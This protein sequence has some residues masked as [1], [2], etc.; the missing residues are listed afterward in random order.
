MAVTDRKYPIDKTKHIGLEVEFLSTYDREQL[1]AIL[2]KSKNASLYHLHG[3]SSV[4]DGSRRG[5]ELSVVFKQTALL[6]TLKILNADLMLIRATVNSTCGLHVHLDMRSRDRVACFVKLAK[7]QNMLF[8]MVAKSRNN[9]A[10]CEKV[11]A[12]INDTPEDVLYII[13][14]S[15]HH[16]CAID[17]NVAYDEHETIEVR[18]HH[19][20]TSF[21]EIINWIRLLITIAD[22]KT[23]TSGLKTYVKRQKEK[24]AA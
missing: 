13:E 2:S 21:F 24:M 7:K 5:H 3:D 16:H 23:M 19:G 4:R 22:D 20:T 17:A 14:Q 12:P 1:V 18:M 15:H 11:Y 9:N 6:Q 8:D 10:F